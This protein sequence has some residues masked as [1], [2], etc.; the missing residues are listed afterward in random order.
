MNK[1]L[2]KRIRYFFDNTLA[3]GP[4]GLL[5]WLGLF[6]SIVIIFISILVWVAGINNEDSLINQIY[7][8]LMTSFAVID[9]EITGNWPFHIASLIVILTGIFVMS[10][11][12]GILTTSIEG[13]LAQLRKGRSRVIESEHTVI[14][15]WSKEILALIKELVTANEHLPSST[16]I[17]ILANKD[18]VEMEAEI[19]D[20]IDHHPQTRIVCRTG[21]PMAMKD[22]EIVS[23]NTAKSIVILGFADDISDLTIMK[24]V[25]AIIYNPKRRDKPYHIVAAIDNP[26]ILDSVKLI[27]EDEIETIHK[28]ELITKIEAQTLLQSGLSI[29]ITDLLD[30]DDNEIYFQSEPG[31]TGRSYQEVI[32]AYDTSVVIGFLT[33]KGKTLLNP[34]STTV[35]GEHDKI[36]AI[37]HNNDTVIMSDQLHPPFDDN[38]IHSEVPASPQAKHILILGWNQHSKKLIQHLSEN[39]PDGSTVTVAASCKNSRSQVEQFAPPTNLTLEHREIEPTERRQLESL[40]FDSIDHVVILPCYEI[41]LSGKPLEIDKLD[42]STMVTLINLRNIRQRHGYSMTITSEILNVENRTLL[43]TPE[44]DDFVVSDQLISLALAQITEN[45]RLASVF[46][47]LFDPQ[48]AEIY[49]KPVTN[50]VKTGQPVSFFTIV[51]SALRQNETAIGYRIYAQR[52]CERGSD[53]NASMKYGIVLNPDKKVPLEFI[54]EDKIIVL[55]EGGGSS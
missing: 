32:L 51:V 42:A 28:G 39:T 8:Y 30:F 13:K 55:S 18:K 41:K 14:L 47:T 15:G 38:V 54:D 36:I 22:L 16:C 3:K 48:R 43:E 40:P 21:N 2:G 20:A 6:I 37:S 44:D 11:F 27:S 1:I 9:A 5:I 7:F 29:V 53:N 4:M 19:H 46:N 23:L 17:A 25:L 52:N 49:L 12:I 24:T 34:P 33:Y 35:L 31:L 26:K 50:Y 45:K 10:T